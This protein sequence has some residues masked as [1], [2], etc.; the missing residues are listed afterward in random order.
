MKK[1]VIIGSGNVAESLVRALWTVGNLPVQVFARNGKKAERIAAICGCPHTSAAVQLAVADLYIIA[2]SDSAVGDVASGLDF[3]EGVVA[4]TAGSLGLDAFPSH[5]PN[6]A[7]IYPLQT[8]TAGRTVDFR[9]IP[10]LIE[11]DNDH[12]LTVVREVANM[13][14]G[15]VRQ[16]SSQKRMMIHAAAV[17]A[18]NFTNYMYT[19]AGELI[20]DAGEDFSMLKPLILETARKALDSRTPGE[21]QTG[22][23]IRHDRQTIDKHIGLLAQRPDIQNIYINISDN[24]W[25]TSKKI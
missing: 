15:R 17:F 3:G 20:E 19:V 6:R 7:V 13:L 11:A 5:I 14:S 1:I 22:P 8:F 10:I 24:I 18:C 12:S 2:V 25:E 9:E 4:H 16:V 23:A 21:V